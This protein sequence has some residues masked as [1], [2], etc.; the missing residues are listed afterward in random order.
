MKLEWVSQSLRKN[1]EQRMKGTDPLVRNLHA[2]ALCFVTTST[3]FQL[4]YLHFP[5]IKSEAHRFS[6]LLS[7][8]II[9]TI[10]VGIV[11]EH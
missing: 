7:G 11:A 5:R 9:G 10:L 3:F 2:R 4:K 6:W 1:E 8:I